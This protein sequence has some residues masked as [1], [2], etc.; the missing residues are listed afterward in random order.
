MP[1][2]SAPTDPE[3]PRPEPEASPSGTSSRDAAPSP[4]PDGPLSFVPHDPP[5][6]SPQEPVRI[7]TLRHGEMNEHELLHL[8]D[9]I[10]DERARSRFRESIYISLFIWIAIAWVVL[11]GPRYLWHAPQLMLPSEALRQREVTQLNAPI[12]APR[13]PAP[14]PAPKVD[15]RTLEHL[16]SQEPPAPRTPPAAPRVPAPAPPAP[17]ITS[18]APPTPAPAL[19]LPTAPQPVAPRTP[20]PVVAEAPTPQPSTRPDFNTSKPS[21]SSS[22]QDAVRNAARNPGGSGAAVGT[23]AGAAGALGT[24]VDILSD[25]QGVNFDPYL[26]R[27]LR[28]IYDQWIPLIPEEARPPLSKAGVTMI[29]FSILPD[30]R[31]GAMHLDGSTHDDALNRAAWGSITAVGQFPPL[32]SQF[33]GPN[34]ELRIHYLVNKQQE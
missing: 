21:A 30:G 22:I 8:L 12:L 24:G 16:R 18:A 10:E 4:S 33:H 34:L 1:L 13:T 11:Y 15:N 23:G 27:I 2:T 6:A 7:R 19:P 28:E 14:K 25:T 5:G 32:P 20:P 3:Q 17:S 9:T 26:R 31:I 29:R